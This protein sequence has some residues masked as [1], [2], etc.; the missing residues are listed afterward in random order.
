[1]LCYLL[2]FMSGIIMLSAER[3]DRFVRF[4][5]LQSIL[6]SVFV[7]VVLLI[8]ALAGLYS[9]VGLLAI[10]AVAIWI[11]LMYRAAL[12]RWYELPVLGRWAESRA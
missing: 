7:T 4:H 12:G 1:V 9:V 10:G 5:A 8:F 3:R 11:L 2:W 6:Y